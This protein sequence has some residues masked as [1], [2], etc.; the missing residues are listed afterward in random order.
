MPLI[1]PSVLPLLPSAFAIGDRITH[2]ACVL[3][4]VA[5]DRWQCTKCSRTVTDAHARGYFTDPAGLDALGVPQFAPLHVAAGEPLPGRPV[6]AGECPYEAGRPYLMC[7]ADPET[8]TS[9]RGIPSQESGPWGIAQN[10]FP[11]QVS[12]AG[13]EDFE[14]SMTATGTVYLRVIGSPVTCAYVPAE[15][16]TEEET[17][18]LLSYAAMSIAFPIDVAVIDL[19]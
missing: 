6:A 14:L 17:V 7:G 19:R 12:C 10:A 11:A 15:Y 4:R 5:V 3:E 13:G 9:M 8:F 1:P 16:P 2:G 18:S